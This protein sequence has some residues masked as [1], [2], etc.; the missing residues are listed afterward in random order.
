MIMNRNPIYG[1]EK[2]IK[3]YARF[4]KFIPLPAHFEHGWTPL[5]DPLP[6][7]LKTNMPLMLVFSNRRKSAWEKHSSIPVEIIGSPMVFYRKKNKIKR[8]SSASGTIVFPSH[9][10]KDIDVKYDIDDFC[11]R[12][13]NLPLEF[14]P[15]TICLHWE[16]IKRNVDKLYKNKGFEVVTAGDMY[17]DQFP[18]NFYNILK[19]YKYSASNEVGTYT[20]YSIEMGIPFFLIGEPA[21]RINNGNDINIDKKIYNINEF[22]YGEIA[23][24]LFSQVQTYISP[25]QLEFVNKELGNNELVDRH[26][27]HFLLWKSLF[28]IIFS[29]RLK[30]V[31]KKLFN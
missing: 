13:L 19:N 28:K 11:N 6:G 29:Y 27:L 14:H 31:L 18:R 24:N 2:L 20:F 10:T 3:E 16:D 21:V 15:F 8:S 4:P 23:K 7:D 30:L 25:E 1:F 26:K 5:E 17:S 12:L 9:S 22:K